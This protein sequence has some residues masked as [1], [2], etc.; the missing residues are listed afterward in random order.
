[1]LRRG[2]PRNDS[3]HVS[4]FYDPGY[5]WRERNDPETNAMLDLL[6]LVLLAVAFGGAVAYVWA[7]V[8]LARTN[9]AVG[10]KAP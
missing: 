2:A 1:L 5:K 6:M 10:D 3:T 9:G 8:D 7:C 4:L